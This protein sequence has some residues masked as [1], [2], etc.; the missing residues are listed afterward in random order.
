M[1]RSGATRHLCQHGWRCETPPPKRLPLGDSSGNPTSPTFHTFMV[2]RTKA[3]WIGCLYDFRRCYLKAGS[4]QVRMLLIASVV[5]AHPLRIAHHG[6]VVPRNLQRHGEGMRPFRRRHHPSSPFTIEGDQQQG[7][8]GYRGLGLDESLDPAPSS[9]ELSEVR[10]DGVVNPATLRGMP[11]ALLNP[12]R[13]P[14]EPTHA[15]IMAATFHNRGRSRAEK[16][17]P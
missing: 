15:P 17:T 10:R 8:L 1:N 7:C 5:V 2:R 14:P 11:T 13:R 6:C 4:T 16:M 12:A 3:C 9:S